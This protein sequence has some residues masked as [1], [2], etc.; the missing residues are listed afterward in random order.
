MPPLLRLQAVIARSESDEAIH[1]RFTAPWIASL[2]LA[3]TPRLL[4]RPRK[5]QQ[6]QLAPGSFFPF[7]MKPVPWPFN[8]ALRTFRRGPRF[9]FVRSDAAVAVPVEPQDERARLLDELLARDLAILVFVKIT[10]VRI[11]HCGVG[12][13]DSFEFGLVQISVVVAIRRRKDPVGILLPF[14]AGVD[15]VVIGVPH[16]RPVVEQDVR[17]GSR[18]GKRKRYARHKQHRGNSD[19]TNRCSARQI[20][21][22]SLQPPAASKRGRRES[23]RHKPIRPSICSKVIRCSNGLKPFLRCSAQQH[24]IPRKNI[25][26]IYLF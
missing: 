7:S 1:A 3:M 21:L 25:L 19:A 23:C 18:L 10:E 22:L 26:F 15:A 17:P 13:A 16:R 9:D 14:V 4:R 24:P 6:S 8:R 5:Q 20:S 12:F 2:A 11:R